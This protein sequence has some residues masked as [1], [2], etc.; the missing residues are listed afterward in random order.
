MTTLNEWIDKNIKPNVLSVGKVFEHDAEGDIILYDVSVVVKTSED[1]VNRVTQPV[2]K[3]GSEFYFGRNEVKNWTSPD[4]KIS[5]EEELLNGLIEIE[6]D[7]GQEVKIGE[8]SLKSLGIK[9]ASFSTPDGKVMA[10]TKL[11]G[12]RVTRELL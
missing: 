10:S 6:S 1:T 7:V 5:N 12:Q 9:Y 2:Y 4:N 11:N 3:V 8:E